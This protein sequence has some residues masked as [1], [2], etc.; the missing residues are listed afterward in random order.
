MN[1]TNSK[2][3]AQMLAKM[4]TSRAGLTAPQETRHASWQSDGSLRDYGSS[5][6]RERDIGPAE[7]A[8]RFRIR[9]LRRSVG[10]L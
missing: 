8:H 1:H 2:M 9:A 4:P 6:L 10:S 7:I 3:S 5:M